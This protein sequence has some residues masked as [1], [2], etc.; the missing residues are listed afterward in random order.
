MKRKCIHSIGL[1]ITILSSWCLCAQE[2]LWLRPGPKFG[3]DAFIHEVS[4]EQ[5]SNFG[6]SPQL[7]VASSTF[8]DESGFTRSLIQFDFN[9]IS[10]EFSLDS[11]ILH[12]FEWPDT[13]GLGMSTV[14]GGLNDCFVHRLLQ[15]WSESEVTWVN[16]PFYSE[17]DPIYVPSD[18]T[19]GSEL[20]ID[21]SPFVYPILN[22]EDDMGWMIKLSQETDLRKR[23]FC[24]SDH[25]DS[26]LR[27]LLI[28]Y[29]GKTMEVS[30]VSHAQEFLYPN[31]FRIGQSFVLDGTADSYSLVDAFSGRIIIH[32]C[33]PFSLK[34]KIQD[35]PPGSYLLI[36]KS[37]VFSG[38]QTLIV[39]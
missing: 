21:V 23:N 18:S 35:V 4:F 32:D 27:P 7:P 2:I 9:S 14:E 8:D 33:T 31:P 25:A 34:M 37:E 26:T 15:D 3:K 10:N 24:S 29:G 13:T 28:L 38:T 19:Q 39:R 11:A 30:S 5:N 1:C 16:S 36:G 17:F 20:K 22:G 12:L 6:D